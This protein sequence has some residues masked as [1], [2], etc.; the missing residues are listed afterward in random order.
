[1]NIKNINFIP[2][3]QL[4]VIRLIG[5]TR[6]A[7]ELKNLSESVEHCPVTYETEGIQI[8]DKLAYLHYFAGAWDWYILE[9]G[10]YEEQAQAYGVVVSSDGIEFSYINIEEL[11]AICGVEVDLHWTATSLSN[12]RKLNSYFENLKRLEVEA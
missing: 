1:M 7:V 11:K 4:S 8:K 9:K 5:V 6:L 2:E 12:I 10:M 3:F